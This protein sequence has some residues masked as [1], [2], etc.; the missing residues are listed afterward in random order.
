MAIYA[1]KG[2]KG[3]T[4]LFDQK[5]RQ[6]LRVSKDSLRI[7]M[8]G[9][10]D[11][12]NSFLGIIRSEALYGQK[13]ISEIQ[14]NLF[15]INSILAGAELSFS[16]SKTKKLEKQI[17]KWE[18]TLPVLKNFLIYGGTREASMIFYSRALSRKAERELVSFSHTQYTNPNILSYMNRLSD[19]LFMLARKLNLDADQKEQIWKRS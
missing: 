17:D 7:S 18:G 10:I 4:S 12:V 8:I 3:E 15:T 16:S 5:S 2:D 14:Q 13:I 11:E 9:A 19:Y 1:K 6:N